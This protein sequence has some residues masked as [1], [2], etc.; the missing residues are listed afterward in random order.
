MSE[1]FQY[2]H[3]EILQPETVSLFNMFNS[4]P[5]S[6]CMYITQASG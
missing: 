2:H 6:D 4:Q 5:V 3:R 1:N